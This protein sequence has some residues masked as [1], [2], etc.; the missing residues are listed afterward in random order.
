MAGNLPGTEIH[1]YCKIGELTT[2][3]L[4]VYY[5][6]T[7]TGIGQWIYTGLYGVSLGLFIYGS[8]LI[9]GGI[10]HQNIHKQQK[11]TVKVFSISV[12]STVAEQTVRSLILWID[13]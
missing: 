12:F 9:I 8:L 5:L 11:S 1:H 10:Q 13:Y 3:P 6:N 2:Y 7:F 4:H